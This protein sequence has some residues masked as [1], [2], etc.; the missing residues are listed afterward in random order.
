[1]KQKLLTAV[2]IVT[3]AGAALWPTTSHSQ[4]VSLESYQGAFLL[5]SRRDVDSM[6]RAIDRVVDQL[7]LF[8]REIARSEIRRRIGAEQRIELSVS[9]DRLEASFDRWGVEIPI[10]GRL[11]QIRGPGGENL[12]VSVRFSDGHLIERRVSDQ[13]ERV[14][15]LSLSPDTEHLTMQVRI[16]SSQL[17]D[18]IRYALSYR[19]QD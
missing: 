6:H 5:A 10:D 4:T 19:R 13:G 8:I 1:V 12:R 3:L 14:N 7:N 2:A 17:P 9:N 16:S 15:V 18:D 11:R